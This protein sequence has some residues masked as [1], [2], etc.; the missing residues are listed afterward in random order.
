MIVIRFLTLYLQNSRK[1]GILVNGIEFAQ[2]R[3]KIGYI[4]ILMV[5]SLVAIDLLKIA[6]LICK[7]K[8]L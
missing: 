1:E 8:G 5:I 3:K 7:V 6:K 2:Q 4:N